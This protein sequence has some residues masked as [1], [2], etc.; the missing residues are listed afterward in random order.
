MADDISEDIA[1]RDD[2]E[3]VVEET[4]VHGSSHDSR[5]GQ[6]AVLGG[7]VGQTLKAQDFDHE[8][9]CYQ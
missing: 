3:D 2:V 5:S 7:P 9:S 6:D 1:V 8:A 4:V